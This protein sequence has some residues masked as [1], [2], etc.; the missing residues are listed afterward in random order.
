MVVRLGTYLNQHHLAS[1]CPLP[2][3]LEGGV[4]V[5]SLQEVLELGHLRLTTGIEL[6]EMISIEREQNKEIGS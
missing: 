6:W 3:Q 2:I 1:P 4:P 5:G